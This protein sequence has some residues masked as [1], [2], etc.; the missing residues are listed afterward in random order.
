MWCS[1]LCVVLRRSKD[2]STPVHVACLIGNTSVLHI[3]VDAGGDLR[4][5]DNFGKTPQDWA[6]QQTKKKRRRRAAQFLS[7]VQAWA[8]FYDFD[9]STGSLFSIRAIDDVC[10]DKVDD[11]VITNVECIIHCEP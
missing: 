8:F 7:Q 3:L 9:W 11:D 1:W 4:I 6:M 5:H 2:G 10:K